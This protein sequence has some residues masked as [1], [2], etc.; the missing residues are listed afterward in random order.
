MKSIEYILKDLVEKIKYELPIRSKEKSRYE[1]DRS[2]FISS[3][4]DDEIDEK[5]SYDVD[6]E[7]LRVMIYQLHFFNRIIHT[8][9]DDIDI[10]SNK[11]VK[12]KL[13]EKP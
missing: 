4:G 2:K 7:T 6:L 10:R 12:E 13:Y 3:H 1:Y 9:E 8:N 5:Y 11:T